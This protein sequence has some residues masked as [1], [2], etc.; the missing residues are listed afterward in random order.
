MRAD[1]C[2]RTHTARGLELRDD[3]AVAAYFQLP[4]AQSRYY[5]FY[6]Y[7][8]HRVPNYFQHSNA[9]QL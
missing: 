5:L 8:L 7:L 9:L 2:C 4:A 3:A 1:N 6:Y